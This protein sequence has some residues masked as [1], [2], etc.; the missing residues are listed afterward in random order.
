MNKEE[1]LRFY[2]TPN[3]GPKSLF[4]MIRE[5]GAAGMFPLHYAPGVHLDYVRKERIQH[6]GQRTDIDALVLAANYNAAVRDGESGKAFCVYLYD[7]ANA[8]LLT[9]HADSAWIEAIVNTWLSLRYVDNERAAVVRYHPI[10]GNPFS[11]LE[12]L[13][14]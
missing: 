9:F 7:F 14:K 13:A 4:Q 3:W 12:E 11:D 6:G 5:L 10:P 1:I 8:N 2:G